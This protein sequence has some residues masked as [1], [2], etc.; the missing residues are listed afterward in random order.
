MTMSVHPRGTYR[1]HGDDGKAR[2]TEI[3]K[4]TTSQDDEEDSNDDENDD[5]NNNAVTAEV[6][7][8]EDDEAAS[9]HTHSFLHMLL[10]LLLV[11]E[12]R[13]PVAGEVVAGILNDG[14][15]RVNEQE[16]SFNKRGTVRLT[17][18]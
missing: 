1:P 10:L 7:V 2:P 17:M 4:I 12:W 6:V 8:K 13:L 11:L 16:V 3:A 9:L 15:A 14:G 18:R 5:D